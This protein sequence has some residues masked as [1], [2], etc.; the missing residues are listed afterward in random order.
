MSMSLAREM[1]KKLTIIYGGVHSGQPPSSI[2]VICCIL[3]AMSLNNNRN[4]NKFT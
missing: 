4:D 3:P 1:D 2:D